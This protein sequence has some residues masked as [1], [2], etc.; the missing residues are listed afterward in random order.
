M[1]NSLALE[2][3]PI[4]GKEDQRLRVMVDGK[5]L[6][7]MFETY[8]SRF[9]DTIAGAYTD[10]LTVGDLKLRMLSSGERFMPLACDCGEWE[11][12]FV[13]GAVHISNGFVSWHQWRN[14]YRDKQVKPTNEHWCYKDFPS[15]VFEESQY[16]A[17]I[18]DAI[19]AL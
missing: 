19:A 9:T 17:T 16:R 14:P 11:C 5:P 6:L 12:W 7:S 15:I 3:L 8:E 13:T 10:W 2:L 4:H 18:A 1:I